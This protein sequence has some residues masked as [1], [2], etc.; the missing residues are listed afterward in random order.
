[1]S[2]KTKTD[3]NDESTSEIN[4]SL[5][6]LS[7]ESKQPTLEMMQGPGS[8]RVYELFRDEM[9]I[10]RAVDVDIP[11]H[12]TDLSRRHVMLKCQSQVTLLD[13]ESRNGV[14]LNGLRVHSAVLHEGDTIQ[15]GSVVFVFHEGH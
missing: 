5:L 10:G 8:P 7:L 11:I 9:V 6:P 4:V 12:S 13:L 3:W 14:Y 15:L 1:M 2:K